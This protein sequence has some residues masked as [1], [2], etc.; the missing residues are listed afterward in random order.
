MD[1]ASNEALQTYNKIFD[2]NL[3]GNFEGYL[4]VGLPGLELSIFACGS[5]VT[6]YEHKEHEES[7]IAYPIN[8]L[9]LL[10]LKIKSHDP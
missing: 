5:V 10:K 8:H 7:S 4:N 6:L 3:S 2:T 1:F 9:E